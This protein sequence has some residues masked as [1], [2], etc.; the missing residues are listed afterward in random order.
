MDKPEGR[1]EMQEGT[2]YAVLHEFV[3]LAKRNVTQGTWDYI[4]GGAETETT[5]ERNRVALD[6]IAFRPRVLRDVEHVDT[7]V[8]LLGLKLQ[9]PLILAPIGSLQDFAPEG[10]VCPSRAAARGGVL[11]MLSSASAPGIEAVAASNPHPKL[12][13]LYVRGDDAWVENHIERAIESGY[14]ALCFTVDLDWYGRRERDLAKRYKTTSRRSAPADHFQARFSWKSLERL[15]KKY[16]IPFIL[17]GIATAE[18]ALMA[19]EHGVESIYVSNHGGRQLDHGKGSMAVL[20]EIVEAVKGRAEII[21]DGGFLRGADI[22]KA[23]A[24]GADAVG[25]GRLQ[26]LAMAAGGEDGLVRMIEL[27]KDEVTRCLGLLGV[28]SFAELDKSYV[29]P[30]APLARSWMDSAFPLLREGY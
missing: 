26:G 27:L 23:M 15:R 3:T 30:V 2:E 17:K 19:L 12:F 8:T 20:P 16:S 5:Q 25:I 13:Q 21:V 22:V 24:L 7:S 29:E 4:V 11:H 9:L 14:K 18:D 6:S 28:T 10:G 1:P